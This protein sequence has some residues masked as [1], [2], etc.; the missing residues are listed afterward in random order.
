MTEQQ[1]LAKDVQSRSDMIRQNV[2]RSAFSCPK[3]NNYKDKGPAMFEK[4][5]GF[6]NPYMHLI[7]CIA[8]GT[9]NNLAKH[10]S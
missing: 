3:G 7:K 4:G 8:G 1:N 10:S 5:S 9:V 6:T 2:L